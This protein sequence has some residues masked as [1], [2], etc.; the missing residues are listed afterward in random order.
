MRRIRCAQSIPP[1]CWATRAT[2]YTLHSVVICSLLGTCASHASPL[3][4]GSS[5]SPTARPVNRRQA[6]AHEPRSSSKTISRYPKGSGCTT[7][8]GTTEATPLAKCSCNTDRIGSQ[9]APCFQGSR[10]TSNE[11]RGTRTHVPYF[12]IFG[13]D[14]AKTGAHWKTEGTDPR[15]GLASQREQTGQPTFRKPAAHARR[16]EPTSATHGHRYTRVCASHP[17]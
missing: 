5:K 12:S 8:R 13:G 14:N 3:A 4:Q 7:K 10:H 6:Q 17:I 2:T 15:K 9:R 11:E 1:V 16:G